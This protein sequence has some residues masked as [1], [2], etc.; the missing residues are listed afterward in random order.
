VYEMSANELKELRMER[1]LTQEQAAKRLG[2]S[3]PYLALLETGKRKLNDRLTRRV[4]RVLG[5]SPAA[6]PTGP[7]PVRNLDDDKLA[8]ELAA[9]GY[10][11]FAYMKGVWRR[12]PAEVL[13]SALAKT[14]LEPRLVE[15]LPWLLLK[16][17]E[18]GGPSLVTSARAENLTNKLGYVTWLARQ[19]AERVDASDNTSRVHTLRKLEQALSESRLVAEGT[20]GQDSLSSKEKEWLRQTRPREAAYWN[21]LT[22]WRPEHLSYAST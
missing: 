8:R 16:Y 21:L 20:L 15:A 6:L 1:G 13:L 2:V 9:L 5:A 3:Q 11:G 10:P 7:S 12:N 18:V 14:D 17:P 22:K 19:V 4:V